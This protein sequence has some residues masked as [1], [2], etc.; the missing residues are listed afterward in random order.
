MT[1][2][3]ADPAAGSPA[4]SLTGC[5]GSACKILFVPTM[6]FDQAR[7]CVI[8]HVTAER[9]FASPEEVALECAAGRVLAEEIRTDRDYPA[10]A[11]SVRDGFA[12]RAADVPGSLR[13]IGEVRAGEIFTGEV[14][15]GEAVEIMTGA[16]VPRGADAVVM[17]E[18]VTRGS[19]GTV[20]TGRAADRGQFI[21][22]R[23][24]EAQAG[25]AILMPGRRLGFAD[26]AMLAAVGKSWVAVCPKPR[27]ALL[28][29]GDEIVRVTETPREFQ[30][31]NSNLYSLAAQVARAG[32]VPMLLPV[33]KDE[34][35]DTR[36][37][38]ERG[39]TA[40]LLLISGGVSA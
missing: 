26:V 40:D 34:Y 11:R 10:L 7:A 5:S 32:G 16:P 6:S 8:E 23:G 24:C 21:S 39:L 28:A 3:G 14:G 22:P 20:T 30:I 38:I 1:P 31:R 29:T 35:D 33:A 36:R 12:V 15:L 25:E 13:V 17:V 37:L 18:H 2:A 4:L 9:V 19:S 27:I